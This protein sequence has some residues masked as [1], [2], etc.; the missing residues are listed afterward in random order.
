M[1]HGSYGGGAGE[2]VK[3]GKDA[4]RESIASLELYI[5]A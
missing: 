4:E 5:W 2:R 3:K 1:A